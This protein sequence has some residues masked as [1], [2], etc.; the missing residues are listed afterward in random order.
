MT[1]S[2]ESLL[3]KW[4]AAGDAGDF[5]AFDDYLHSDVVVHAP[6]GLSTTGLDAEKEMWR[7]ALNGLPDIRHDIEEAISVDSTIAARVVVTGTHRGEF[8]GIPGT[9]RAFRIDQAIFAHVRDRKVAEIWEIVDSAAFLQQLG[10][11]SL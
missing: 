5:D 2:G 7:A 1:T 10:V 4:V 6:L 3:H 8:L 11:I 9:G